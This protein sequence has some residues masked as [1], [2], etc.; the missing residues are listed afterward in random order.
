[1]IRNYGLHRF[2]CDPPPR[3][4]WY[5]LAVWALAMMPVA[6]VILIAYV[7]LWAFGFIK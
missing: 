5:P 4:W 6:W 7:V 1:M 2:S 3:P